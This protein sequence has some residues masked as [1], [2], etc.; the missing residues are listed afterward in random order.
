[1]TARFTSDLL[2]VWTKAS[3][4]I[5]GIVT[6]PLHC[7]ILTSQVAILGPYPILL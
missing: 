3:H 2:V 6:F 1:M 4:Y 7:L 5:E